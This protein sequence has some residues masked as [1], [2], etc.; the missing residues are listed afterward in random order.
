MPAI[1]CRTPK[2]RAFEH[3]L[4]LLLV[5]GPLQIQF[6]QAFATPTPTQPNVIISG[7]GPAG[8]LVSILLNNIGIKSTIFEEAHDPDDWSSKSYAMSLNERGKAALAAG[9]CLESVVRAGN[10]KMCNYFVDG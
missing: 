10:E 1:S 6:S 7:G 5:L 3:L 8:L 4:L 2:W 9:N